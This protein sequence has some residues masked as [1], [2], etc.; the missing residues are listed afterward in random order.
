MSEKL[1]FTGER[2]TPECEREIW[3]EHMHRYVFAAQFCGG[4]RVLDAACGEGYGSALLAR[5]AKEVTG[6]DNSHGA[7]EHARQ[8]Y[9]GKDGLQFLPADCTQLPFEAGQFD[10]VVALSYVT[11]LRYDVR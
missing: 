11:F 9:S 7:I 5:S 2:F 10:M 6:V 1:E 3:Y 4:A 8:R